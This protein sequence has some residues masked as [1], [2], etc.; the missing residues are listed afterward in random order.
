MVVLLALLGCN[1]EFQWPWAAGDAVSVP[2]SDT[3]SDTGS[4]PVDTGGG[5]TDTDSGGVDTDVPEDCTG[6][7]IVKATFDDGE[8]LPSRNY[9][10]YRLDESGNVLSQA[11]GKT[12]HSLIL[13]CG[14]TRIWLQGDYKTGE[15]NPVVH[16]G[17]AAYMQPKFEVRLT[18]ETPAVAMPVNAFVGEG[19]A[20]CE[21]LSGDVAH[22]SYPDLDLRVTISD[23]SVLMLEPFSANYP[24]F[25]YPGSY[26]TVLGSTFIMMSAG[27]G[28]A[29]IDTIDFSSD[30]FAMSMREID[31]S[32]DM[33]F[34]TFTC[35]VNE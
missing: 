34:S 23:G 10:A 31:A 1:V 7:L 8:V 17:D 21:Y 18:D 24:A 22:A 28:D 13:P 9:V 6:V 27:P 4:V 32:D 5:D 29:V 16:Q 3:G 14:R 11:E 19:I 33:W 30:S 35:Y 26:V 20:N 12:G 15:G 25:L 2:P